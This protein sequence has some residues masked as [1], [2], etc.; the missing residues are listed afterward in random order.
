M[1]KVRQ[2]FE[3]GAC[4][5][6]GTLV[7]TKEGLVAIEKLKVGD[8]VL[9]RPEN[10]EHGTELAYKRVVKTFVH[11][12]KEIHRVRAWDNPNPCSGNVK[13]KFMD[14]YSTLDHPFWV[15]DYG[16]TAASKIPGMYG[17]AK[18]QMFDGS[19]SWGD[20]CN[21]YQTGQNDVVWAASSGWEGSGG[22][23]NIAV[24]QCLNP[25]VYFGESQPDLTWPWDEEYEVD[26]EGYIYKTTV[27]NIEVE[28]YHTYFVGEWGVWVH[29][30]NCD[31]TLFKTTPPNAP[32]RPDPK[33]LGDLQH[34]AFEKD[35]IKFIRDNPNVR[36]FAIVPVPGAGGK[37]GLLTTELKPALV[38]EDGVKG[39]IDISGMR[40][41][42]A[43]I[44]ENSNKAPQARNYIRVEGQELSPTGTHIFI[45]RKRELIRLDEPGGVKSNLDILWRV[46]QALEQNK[47]YRWAFE[48]GAKMNGGE[49]IKFL[50]AKAWIDKIKSNAPDCPNFVDDAGK[51]LADSA[52]RLDR[53]RKMLNGYT[54]EAGNA[55]GPKIEYRNEGALTTFP[56]N[57][58]TEGTGT[59][60]TSLTQ[61]QVNA[62]LPQARQ[63]WLD[64]GASASILNK[65]TFQIDDLPVGFAGQTQGTQITLDATGAGWGWFADAT[66]GEQS[67]FQPTAFATE[68]T[69]PEGS[70]AA[71]KLDLLTVMIHE[72]GH[73]LGMPSTVTADDVMS[74]YLAPGQRRLPDAVDIA[75]LQAE[76]APF[77]MGSITGTRVIPAPASTTPANNV[78]T[79]AQATSIP[80]NPQFNANVNDWS[81]Q[82]VGQS[83][84][85]GSITLSETS[86]SQTS[87][88][89]AFTLGSED[90][91]LSFTVDHLNLGSST[92]NA[93]LDLRALSADPQAPRNVLY[94][95]D[96]LGFG[97]T[98]SSVTLRNIHI[99]S[100]P[101]A[102]DDTLTVL[103]DTPTTF[104]PLTTASEV[105]G[106]ALSTITS[107]VTVNTINLIAACAY[108]T[109]A[110][111]TFCMQN[112]TTHLL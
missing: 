67:E 59:G 25:N 24:S 103:E 10:P 64:A 19:D 27:Y 56:Q 48:F 78:G 98:D 60:L 35:L 58:I 46:T 97:M 26:G 82:G 66:P 15:D 108:S 39:R 72:L 18:L 86:T 6:A 79:P 51:I 4:F 70:E 14:M 62:L 77:Y 83:H 9:S 96:L 17:S 21:V 81:I 7:H 31:I 75:A 42:F 52:D 28:D 112:G 49:R 99:S 38:F 57:V 109:S 50:E 100:A 34:F 1:T 90:R 84:A 89:Q 92:T 85:D 29:N 69:A 91:F 105:D 106:D 40:Q 87:L 73:V 2:W 36:G 3:S 5:I 54:D 111:L 13:A 95:F 33:L 22:L 101:Q 61:A 104:T 80:L 32:Q 63:Y 68:F 88:M 20:H 93:A 45:D 41:E 102:V 107:E 16:W 74:Q 65:A 44:F 71:S 110:R 30:A 43:V 76:G 11:E 23:W 37:V 55:V 12:D 47:D 8:L 94:S 53:I